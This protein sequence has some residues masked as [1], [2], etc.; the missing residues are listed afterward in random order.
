MGTDGRGLF[1][2]VEGRNSASVA[3]R[4]T[5]QPASWC[6]QVR[7]VAIDLCATFRTAVHRALPHAAVV[8]DCFHPSLRRESP[9]LDAI[10]FG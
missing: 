9:P 1:G 3:D 7:Y 10:S 2:Q 8:V 5:S 4:L 6:T